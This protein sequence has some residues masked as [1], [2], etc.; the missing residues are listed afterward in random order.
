MKLE[1]VGQRLAACKTYLGRGLVIVHGGE[2]ID[3]KRGIDLINRMLTNAQK[4][5]LV[6]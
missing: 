4:G 5:V 2:V 6:R 3:L 1:C